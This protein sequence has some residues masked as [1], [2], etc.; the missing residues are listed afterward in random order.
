MKTMVVIPTVF[1]HDNL[2]FKVVSFFVRLSQRQTLS[3]VRSSTKVDSSRHVGTVQKGKELRDCKSCEFP[4]G[5]YELLQYSKPPKE[6]VE[7]NW[8]ASDDEGTLQSSCKIL[9]LVGVIGHKCTVCLQN[10]IWL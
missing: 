5:A 8:C 9:F 2:T 4:D 7:I 1:F 3:D 10:L 6:E